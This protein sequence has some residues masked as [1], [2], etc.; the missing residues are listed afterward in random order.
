MNW[1]RESAALKQIWDEGTVIKTEILEGEWKV[2]MA[3]GPMWSF[4]DHIKII[5]KGKG[6]N[7]TTIFGIPITWGRFTTELVGLVYKG[8][9][10][11]I[12]DELVA[13]IDKDP[14]TGTDGEI[15]VNRI[16]GKF[17]LFSRWFL[18]YFWMTRVVEDGKE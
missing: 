11:R 17:H 1:H 3:T 6:K 9:V 14:K 5:T 2:E 10:L 4:A 8:R 7:V 12:V 18:G 15:I 16:L 13:D